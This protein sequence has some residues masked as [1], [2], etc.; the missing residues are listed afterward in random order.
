MPDLSDQHKH[1]LGD[2]ILELDQALFAGFVVPMPDQAEIQAFLAEIGAGEATRIEQRDDHLGLY[3]WVAD[4][5]QARIAVDGGAIR[6][7]WRVIAWPDR[8]LVAQRHAVW[9]EPDGTL[10][11]ITPAPVDGGDSLFAPDDRETATAK[12]YRILHV[13][14]DR[15]SEIAERVA[16]LKGGQRAYEER[17]AAKAGQSLYD[18]IAVKHF[19]DPL[20]AALPAFT[21]ACDVFDARLHRL[22]D[23]IEPRPDDYDEA[24]EDPWEP[25]WET[26]HARDKLID[27]D[28]DRETAMMAVEDGLDALGLPDTREPAPDTEEN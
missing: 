9:Q 11:D 10:V 19:T 12:R 13:S 28:I 24:V 22:P 14:P 15:S 6:F 1:D 27:W 16:A 21:A 23:L 7:G 5:V 8:L 17:R 20:I 26:E 3:H 4:G 18:W 2:A 25:A